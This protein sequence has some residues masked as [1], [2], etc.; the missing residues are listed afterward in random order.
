MDGSMHMSRYIVQ[1]FLID[2]N[3]RN[4]ILVLEAGVGEKSK[5][6]F[7]LPKNVTTSIGFYYIV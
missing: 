7:T 3:E 1:L 2:N 6:F 4:H 5:R